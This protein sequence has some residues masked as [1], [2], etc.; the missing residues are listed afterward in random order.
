[1][2]LALIRCP[3]PQPPG[4]ATLRRQLGDE[5]FSVMRWSDEPHRT[6][7]PH[8]HDHDESL[9]GLGGV[10]TFHIAGTDHRLEPGDRLMLPRG[11]VHAAT[12]GPDGAT[13]LIGER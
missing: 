5:G 13:Y 2:K 3:D 11:T 9:C 4:E 12:V 10:I 6:Y 8:R 7:A 1:M